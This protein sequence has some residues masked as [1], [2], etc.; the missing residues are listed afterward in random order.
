[1][2]MSLS[3]YMLDVGLNFYNITLIFSIR[4]LYQLFLTKIRDS[5]NF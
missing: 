5:N 3:G 1:M 4:V 2:K